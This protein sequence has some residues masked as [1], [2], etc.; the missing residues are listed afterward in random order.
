MEELKSHNWS[1]TLVFCLIFGILGFIT[2][3]VTGGR[4]IGRGD[5]GMMIHK[6]HGD[7]MGNMMKWESKDGEEMHFQVDVESG[8]GKIIIDIDT[9]YEENGK[10]IRK[11]EKK[12]MK[13]Q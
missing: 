3:K 6:L 13:Q 2:G 9:T 8:D 4:E 11:V 12:V 1:L 5:H 7:R 10:T